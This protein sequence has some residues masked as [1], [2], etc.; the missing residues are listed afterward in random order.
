MSQAGLGKSAY[1][2]VGQY[3]DT[4]KDEEIV[5]KLKR[6]RTQKSSEPSS[7]VHPEGIGRAASQGESQTTQG[8]GQA[9]LGESAYETV[10]QYDDTDK[11][12]EVVDK[13]KRKRRT[14]KSSGPS[15]HESSYQ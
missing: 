5:D 10:G 1:E 9:G 3:D 15:S 12:E 11:D 14:Q 7:Q 13:L 2:T 6:K 8:M 4:D